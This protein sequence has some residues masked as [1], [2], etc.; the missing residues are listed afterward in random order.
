VKALHRAWIGNDRVQ[1]QIPFKK[2]FS[3][4]DAEAVLRQLDAKIFVQAERFRY[5]AS[6]SPPAPRLIWLPCRPV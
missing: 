3:D 6:L 2:Q 4:K 1:E 5:K